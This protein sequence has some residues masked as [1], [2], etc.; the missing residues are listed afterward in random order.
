MTWWKVTPEHKKSVEERESW[1][2]D[3][4][5]IV[6]VIGWRWGTVLVETDDNE[7]PEFDGDPVDMYSIDYEYE[8]ESTSDGCYDDVVWPEHM[9]EDERTRLT[10]LWEEDAYS[11]WEEDGWNPDDTELWFAGPLSIEKSE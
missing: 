6:R 8:F 3:G 4:Q 11:S 9:P 2:K 5:T 7:P 1:C 10:E